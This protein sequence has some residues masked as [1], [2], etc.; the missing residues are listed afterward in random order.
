MEKIATDI[1]AFE[2]LRKGGFACVDKTD[3]PCPPADG[4][5]GRRFFL[6]RPRRLGKRIGLAY[7]TSV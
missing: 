1:Y 6:S 4:S 2:E 3:F 5:I 7:R